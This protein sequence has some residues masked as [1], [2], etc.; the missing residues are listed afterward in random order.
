[1]LKL[2]VIIPVY[3][4]EATLNRCVESVLAQEWPDM[5]VIL[6][7]DGSPDACPKL[8]DE[9]ATKDG[10]VRVVHKTNGGLSDARNVGL[11]IATGDLITFV[12]SDDCLAQNT[13]DK[14]LA[15]MDAD[16]DIIE[17]PVLRHYDSA[18]QERLSF[19]PTV[20]RDMNDYWL[21]GQAYT[22][23][24]AWN[25]IYRCALFSEVR[26]PVGRVFED[27]ATLPHLL[28]RAHKVQQTDHGCYYYCDNSQGI[29]ATATGAELQ[30]LLMAHLDNWDVTADEEYYLHLLNIQLSVC[31]QTGS[32][33][34]LPQ[35][36]ISYKKALPVV[37]RIKVILLNLLG[38]GCLCRLYRL[39][40]KKNPHTL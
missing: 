21:R 7:D 28:R 36:H 12:D 39:I 11:D 35:R 20:Y 17:F 14:V 2:S 15:A 32:Q 29:T 9:W 25:K 22:H 8:C 13:Y 19:V 6:V 4:V 24:Y 16:T 3:K 1:M 34:L 23:T 10:R 38:I 33:P 37:M 31:S 30:Q 26:F 27:V 18:R 5:E 40:F